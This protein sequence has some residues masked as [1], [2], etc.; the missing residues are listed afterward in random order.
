MSNVILIV[1]DSATIRAS[2]KHTLTQAGY[3]V[4]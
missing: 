3:D 4:H 1:D 2:V